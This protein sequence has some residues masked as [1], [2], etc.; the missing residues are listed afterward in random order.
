MITHKQAYYNIF[1]IMSTYNS[2]LEPVWYRLAN[3][4]AN[5][6]WQLKPLECRLL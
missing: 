5:G 1:A 6:H 2:F 4:M 3:R